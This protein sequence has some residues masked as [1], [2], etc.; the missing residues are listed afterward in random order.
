MMDLE[1]HLFALTVV[2]H[3]WIQQP[4]SES[5][6]LLRQPPTLSLSWWFA[7]DLQETRCLHTTTSRQLSHHHTGHASSF[8]LHAPWRAMSNQP[9]AICIHE[10]SFNC[11]APRHATFQVGFTDPEEKQCRMEVGTEVSPSCNSWEHLLIPQY[12][13]VSLGSQMETA[14]LVHSFLTSIPVC[15]CKITS[16]QNLTTLRDPTRSP[17]TYGRCKSLFGNILTAGLPVSDNCSAMGPQPELAPGGPQ[18]LTPLP[19]T[20]MGAFKHRLQATLEKP[21]LPFKP[22]FRIK[23]RKAATT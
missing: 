5:V 6:G 16:A 12:L 3:T 4:C 18:H 1:H 21:T 20:W 14:E 7:P 11:R 19:S 15:Q 9:V 17:M 10:Q 8:S 23:K 13:A 22:S 2:P